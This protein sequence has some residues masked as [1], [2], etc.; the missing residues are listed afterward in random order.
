[1][2][3]DAILISPTFVNLITNMAL[4]NPKKSDPVSPIN[5][6]A[7]VQLKARNEINAPTNVNERIE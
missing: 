5:I 4:T 7:G 2:L 1:M 6:L 3:I